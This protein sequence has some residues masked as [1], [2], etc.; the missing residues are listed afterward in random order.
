[1]PAELHALAGPTTLNRLS[2]SQN[3][4]NGPAGQRL[5][6]NGRIKRLFAA[7]HNTGTMSS[8][9][10]IEAYIKEIAKIQADVIGISETKR[11]EE[12]VDE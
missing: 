11:S 3:L 4:E 10:Q 8:D 12:L 6:S 1:M 7:T 9:Y 5:Q 2:D